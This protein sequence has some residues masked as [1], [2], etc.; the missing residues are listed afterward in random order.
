MEAITKNT[1]ER[2]LDAGLLKLQ[3]IL[4][5][6]DEGTISSPRELPVEE[7]PAATALLPGPSG[8]PSPAAGLPEAPLVTAT[9]RLNSDEVEDIEALRRE[10]LQMSTKV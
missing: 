8:I 6:A 2:E 5:N 4:S 9:P 10:E 1:V 7:L 3:I